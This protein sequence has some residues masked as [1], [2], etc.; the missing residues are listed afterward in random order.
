MFKKSI[1]YGIGLW[2]CLSQ[3]FSSPSQTVAV[4]IDDQIDQSQDSSSAIY[5]RENLSASIAGK[6]FQ[7]IT[8]GT[9]TKSLKKYSGSGQQS[10]IQATITDNSIQTVT[11]QLGAHYFLLLTLNRFSTEVKDLPR[12]DRKIYTHRLDANYRLVNSASSGSVTGKNISASKRIPVTSKILIQSSKQSILNELIN[13]IIGQIVDHLGNSAF[14]HLTKPPVQA[15]Q[16]TRSA[17]QSVASI[18]SSKV[19]VFISVKLQNLVWP[20]ISKDGKE[21]LILT[22]TNYQLEATDAEIEI[23]GVFVGN[24]S[25]TGP[26][27]IQPGLRR[28]KVIRSGFIVQ[29]KMINAYEGLKLNLLLTP[30][31]EEY[32]RWQSQVA[33]TQKIKRGEKLTDIEVKKAE[34]MYEFLKNSKYELPDNV[35]IKSLY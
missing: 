22:G 7:V 11:Q 27:L 14:S 23:D 8:H 16:Q 25:S 4:F 18:N 20:E 29:E 9:V 35:T 10:N 2:L 12:F 24:S 30:T 15:I 31:D 5:A 6:G 19:Q 33:F 1:Y 32:A 34:G 3:A 21:N 26:V 17:K 13:D 28:L